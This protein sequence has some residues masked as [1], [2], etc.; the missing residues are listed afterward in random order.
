MGAAPGMAWL[1]RHARGVLIVPVQDRDATTS[2]AGA[3]EGVLLVQHEGSCGGPVFYD[4]GR[5]GIG[6]PAGPDAGALALLLM[7]SEA[8]DRFM[9]A[10]GLPLDAVGGLAVARHDRRPRW[11]AGGKDIV[12]WAES[13]EAYAG[14]LTGMTDVRLDERDIRAFFGRPATPAEIV[15]GAVEVPGAAALIGALPAAR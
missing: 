7:T 12:L 6:L 2:T 11:N 5:P 3:R 15:S 8:L 4:I 13:G 10:E 1:L 9:G 14:A